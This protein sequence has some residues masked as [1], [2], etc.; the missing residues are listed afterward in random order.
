M[1]WRGRA[2]YLAGMNNRL[3]FLSRFC[4][5]LVFLGLGGT[6]AWAQALPPDTLLNETFRANERDWAITRTDDKLRELGPEG[7]HLQYLSANPTGNLTSSKV[8]PLNDLDDYSLEVRLRLRGRVGLLWGYRT[9]ASGR[10]P[11][12]F[13]M[14]RLEVD[15]VT[16]QVALWHLRDNTWEKQF[17]EP[18]PAGFDAAAVHSLRVAR[19]GALVRFYLD[20]R[21]LPYE[22]PALGWPGPDHDVGL[23]LENGGDEAW[24]RQLLVR[25]HSLIRLAPGIPRGL[26][27]ERLGNGISTEREELVPLIA[28]NGRSLFFVRSMGDPTI[29]AKSNT[30][31]FVAERGADGTWGQPHSLGSPVNT[32]KNNSITQVAPDGQSLLI[33]GLYDAA[34]NQREGGVSQTTR[35]ADGTWSSPLVFV[36]G[37]VIPNMANYTSRFIDASGTVALVAGDTRDNPGKSDIYVSL[38]QP[39]GSWPA[40][41][42]L[43][44][45]I[46][47][48]GNAMSPFLAPDG[49]TLYFSSDSFPGYGQADV[50]VSTRLDDSWTKWSPPLNLG[51]GVNTPR[52]DAYFSLPASGEYAYL[53]STEPGV[54]SY[55]TDI[56]RLLLPKALKPAA[57]VLVRGRVLDARTSQPIANAEMRYEQLPAGKEVGR[58]RLGGAGTYEI[59]LPAGQ[60]YGFRAEAPGYLAASN[61]LDLRTATAYAERTQDLFLLP[62]AKP[63]EAAAARVASLQLASSAP[64]VPGQLKTVAVAAVVEDKI[65]LNNLFFVQGKPELLPTSFPELNRLAETLAAHPTL[66]IRLDGHTDNTGDAKDPKPNQVLSEQ[67]AVAVKAYLVKQRID[68]ARLSTRGYGGGRPVAPN[69]SEAHKA[70]NRRVEFVIVNR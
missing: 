60:Q 69:D 30:D 48:A 4:F 42:S 56:Y 34:G 37:L 70:R 31:I 19:E 25:H 28:A 40:L 54:V 7:Y 35:Q 59:A 10:V 27:R 55:D 58:L 45:T 3:R 50:F 29:P 39:D 63:V 17:I 20:G 47:T 67:R 61:N 5:L 53:V 32:P 8:L 44:P 14:L 64:A 2:A 68:G 57:T 13:Q 65:T 51:P 1:V 52:D 23:Y 33:D 38:R 43:G 41:R 46:N 24:V 62:L 18:V 66:Q 6:A 12:D 21:V 11:S 9:D 15:R 26:R 22:Q 36:E 16:P 49:K